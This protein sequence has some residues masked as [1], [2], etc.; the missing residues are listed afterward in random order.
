MDVDELK[1]A[2]GI[3]AIISQRRKT[4]K[5]T[6][7]IMR[8]FDENVTTF[9]PEELVDAYVAMAELAKKRMAELRQGGTLPYPTTR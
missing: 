5:L 2:N 6:F 9:I 4:G 3:T 7:A 8:K 1:D